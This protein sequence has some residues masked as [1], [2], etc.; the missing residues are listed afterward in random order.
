[1]RTSRALLAWVVAACVCQPAAAQE[2]AGGIAGT[3]SDAGRYVLAGAR[4][5]L[6]PRGAS[7]VSDAQGRFSIQNIAA[8]DVRPS[9]CRG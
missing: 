4:I 9:P 7:A 8:G 1:M 3:V 5:E 2:R 6:D